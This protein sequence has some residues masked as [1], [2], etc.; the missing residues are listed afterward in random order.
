MCA[1]PW[2]HDNQDEA[3]NEEA[4]AGRA[5]IRR[6]TSRNIMAKGKKRDPGS[7]VP[8]GYDA[9]G[10]QSLREPRELG[11]DGDGDGVPV[12]FFY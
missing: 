12:W 2:G 6:L 3:R 7:Q 11:R 9:N 4:S 1:R 8:V 5:I 10:E